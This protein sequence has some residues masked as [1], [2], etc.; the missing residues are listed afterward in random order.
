MAQIFGNGIN[1]WKFQ[2]DLISLLT[3]DVVKSVLE[4]LV[5]VFII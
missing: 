4:S 5:F 1:S 3:M 2:N